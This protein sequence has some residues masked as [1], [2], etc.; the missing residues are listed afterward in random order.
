MKKTI[1]LLL[2][3]SLNLF[4]QNK[5][6]LLA[7]KFKLAQ[8]YEKIGKLNK[9]EV[10]YK[11]LFLQSPGN[12][13]FLKALNNIYLKEKKYSASISL[14]KTQIKKIPNS[15]DFYGL[16]GNTYY[17]MGN[18]Q[19]A[20]NVWDEA[21]RKFHSPTDFRIIAN[22]AINNRA[23]DKA[24]EILE[25]G[26]KAS[27][28]N[29][30]FSFDLGNLYAVTMKFKKATDEYC[31]ILNKQPRQLSLIENRI[32][33]FINY[34]GALKDFI[35]VVSQ[36]YKKTGRNIYLNLLS[37]IYIQK[38]KF[39]EAFKIIKKLD[40]TT[41][42]N[43]NKLYSF[44]SEALRDN[45]FNIAYKA[46]KIITNKYPA[47]PLIAS[48]KL[49]IA[50][51]LEKKLLAKVDSFNYNWLPVKPKI[52]LPSNSIREIIKA[53]SQA[54]KLLANRT[55]R[56]EALFNSAMLYFHYS[57]DIKS[58]KN[59]LNR[60]I[61]SFPN[62]IYFYRAK[63]AIVNILLR[64]G[65]FNSSERI[66]KNIAGNKFVPQSIKTEANFKLARIYYWLGRFTESLKYLNK[67]TGDLSG[68]RANDALELKTLIT[69]FQKDSLNL[70]QFSKADYF[71][72]TGK[73]DSARIILFNIS[74]NKNLFLLNKIAAY[75]LSELLL[76]EK[77]FPTAAKILTDLVKN[78]E[79][80][81][82]AD[83]SIF[84]LGE[85]NQFIFKNYKKA[86]FWYQRL[87]E[88]FPNSLYL[89]G[90]REMINLIE[91]K[92]ERKR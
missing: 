82:Y 44:A 73:K 11:E 54:T 39:R 18:F 67:I 70:T 68:D 15:I 7:S 32:S 12:R 77:D 3:L 33:L 38:K 60:I 57:N 42:D 88:K 29:F 2:F 49:G 40:E 48:V 55:V 34:H 13:Q 84:L 31:Q 85:I 58:A 30:L 28:N 27:N 47:S 64:A 41:N 36:Y 24:I 4:S 14:L 22:Y 53:Y 63:I 9:A 16:L 21:L 43:G 1:L 35:D 79:N 90:S 52:T 20:F 65:N 19:K 72:N 62:S 8:S 59:Y 81:M 76:S 87:L 83:K 74:R 25:K 92:S 61:S 75:K 71:V 56:A 5:F 80:P 46:F 86:L 78:E 69:T 66:L 37:D 10:I 50:K 51:A 45:Y 89:E 26:K 6:G 17:T 23:F 91:E